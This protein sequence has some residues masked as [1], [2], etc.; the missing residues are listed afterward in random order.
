MNF[1]AECQDRWE[2]IETCSVAEDPGAEGEHDEDTETEVECV[3]HSEVTRHYLVISLQ[4]LEVIFPIFL[5]LKILTRALE[6][7][8]YIHIYGFLCMRGSTGRDSILS[9][10]KQNYNSVQIGSKHSNKACYTIL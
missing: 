5:V 8:D 10:K 4:Y 3:H 6:N 7:A 9:H 2:Q 1:N